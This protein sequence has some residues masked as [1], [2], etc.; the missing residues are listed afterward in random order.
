MK[1]RMILILCG[2]TLLLTASCAK[3]PEAG[4]TDP[5]AGKEAPKEN[6]KSQ[7]AGPGAENESGQN[8][9]G[10]TSGESG[11][12]EDASGA[13]GTAGA[14]SSGETWQ[15]A[16]LNWLQDEEDADICTYS[17]ICVDDDEIPELVKDTGVE[18][19]G[20][21]IATWH[22]G[23]FDYL[24]T[25]RL[26]FT[27]VEKGNLLCNSD[28]NMGYYYDDI[29]AIESRLWKYVAGG[30]YHDPES[31]PQLD[32]EENNYIYEYEWEG[33]PVEESAYEQRFQAVYPGNQAKTPE[34]YYIL[35][36]MISILQ[37]GETMSAN[38]RYELIVQDITWTEAQKACEEKGG[39]LATITT[40]EEFER[41]AEQILAEGQTSVTFFVGAADKGD[42]HG[43]AWLEPGKGPYSMLSLYKALFADY[44]LEGEP[45]YTG[46]AEDGREVDED[47]V[48]LIYRSSEGRC[49]LNDVADDILAEAP[50]FAGRVGYIC[51]YNE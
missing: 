47:C 22:D 37:T 31:G 24:Q 35:D 34:N 27:Y 2:M 49:Y 50:S 8:S 17:L 40:R 12:A 19:G 44:W 41:I 42:T 46:V 39:Y 23:T 18:A 36:D 51:E 1:K 3:Q 5:E 4:N 38:H 7:E 28:G 43:H 29:Y 45:S 15:Q 11:M 32:A 26:N 33:E 48:S 6:Q 21:R 20:C 13:G 14:A 9:G 25:S 10:D 30:T 16:Y